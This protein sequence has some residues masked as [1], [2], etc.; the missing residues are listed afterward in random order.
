[1]NVPDIAKQLKDNQ[2]NIILIYA[3]NAVGKTR[4]SVGYKNL[5]KSENEGNHTGVYYNAFSEDLFVWE[6]DEQNDNT[7]IK[8]SV[9]WS[10]LN[11]YHSFID[12][13]DVE[14]KLAMYNPKYKFSFN[15]H[16]DTEKGI[17][18][19]TF[20]LNDENQTPIK[21]SRGEERIFVWC[22]FSALFEVDA[23]A[24]QQDAHIFI[25]DPVSSLDEHNIFVTA[26]SIFDLI[27]DHYLKKR[28]IIT[29]HH[30]GLFSILFNK[31]KKGE[32][33]GRYEK[34][35]KP[36]ILKREGDRLALNSFNNDVFLFHLHLIQTLDSAIKTELYAFHFVLLRQ[37][38]ENI[39][40][41]L[42]VGRVSY[43]LEQI[44]LGNIDEYMETINSLSHKNIYKLQFN[45]M[46]ESE[47]DIFK[48][49]F[50]KIQDKYHFVF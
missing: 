49:I 29:T 30:I 18:S 22:F 32:K 19:V 35:T 16:E 44:G 39:S 7:N 24:G 45:K 27:E 9:I 5:T 37:L 6:N 2:E 3:F 34:L 23:W 15:L 14:E 28:I 26:E 47:E 20:Y 48:E 41:F 42:G 12:V 21:I 10:S 38:L 33:S 4:L 25:D 50:Q 13:I 11:Q 46:A 36:F 17:E 40:S 31:L 1:M 8:L 43:V